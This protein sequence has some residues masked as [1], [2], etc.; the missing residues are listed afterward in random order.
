[1]RVLISAEVVC[2]ESHETAAD[3]ARS[4]YTI[5]SC[6]MSLHESHVRNVHACLAVTCYLQF[7]QSDRD[8]ARATAVNWGGTDTE[9]RVSTE[10]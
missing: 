2:L 9:I 7:W 5:E 4:V 10:S 6:T 3:S 1:M 8:L